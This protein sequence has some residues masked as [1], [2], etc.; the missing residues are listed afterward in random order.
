MQEIEFKPCFLL[1]LISMLDKIFFVL[2]NV[3]YT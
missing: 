1:V 2:S 3:Q